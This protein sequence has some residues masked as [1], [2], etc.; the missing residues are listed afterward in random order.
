MFIDCSLDA[1]SVFYIGQSL[2]RSILCDNSNAKSATF[3]ASIVGIRATADVNRWCDS[4][5]RYKGG[6]SKAVESVESG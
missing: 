6:D 5:C 3:E 4:R 1:I 2:N